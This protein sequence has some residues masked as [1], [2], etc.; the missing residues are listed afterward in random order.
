M[1][2]ALD[3]VGPRATFQLGDLC[4]SLYVLESQGLPVEPGN[5]RPLTMQSQCEARGSQRCLANI[6]KHKQLPHTVTAR[7]TT[8]PAASLPTRNI[9]KP[10]LEVCKDSLRT[11]TG[12][13]SAVIS[14]LGPLSPLSTLPPS[15]VIVS[16]GHLISSEEPGS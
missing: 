9:R 5:K 13:R 3:L 15:S 14:A 16:S 10:H 7:M 6:W 4:Y 1:L 8:N 11:R 12:F 2:Y